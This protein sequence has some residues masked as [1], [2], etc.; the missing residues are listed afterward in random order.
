MTTGTKFVIAALALIGIGL[1]I[2]NRY[3]IVHLPKPAGFSLL[4]RESAANV[5][6]RGRFVSRHG[7]LTYGFDVAF[8]CNSQRDLAGNYGLTPRIRYALTGNCLYL[9]PKRS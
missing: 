4:C 1:M 2:G 5:S 7:F 3:T 6:H 8:L 9:L